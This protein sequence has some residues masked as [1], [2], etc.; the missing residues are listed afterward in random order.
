MMRS[1]Y[2]RVVARITL[3][4][5]AHVPT[6]RGRDR[7]RPQV[8]PPPRVQ[9]PDPGMSYPTL[10]PLSLAR[11]DQ[12]LVFSPHP[13]APALAYRTS[14]SSLSS[15]PVVVKLSSKQPRSGAYPLSHHVLP[16]KGRVT[17]GART[18]DLLLS[19]NP[20]SSVTVRTRVPGNCAYLWG[21]RRFR[22]LRLSVVYQLVPSG[23]QYGE[24]LERRRRCKRA[25]LLGP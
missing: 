2:R 14:G 12:R 1:C 6:R 18:R 21:F 23:R 25:V 11:C 20:M 19:H 8:G 17:D 22:G 3:A 5:E 15:R 4:P 9:Q 24:K 13:C 10:T 16:A 7:A